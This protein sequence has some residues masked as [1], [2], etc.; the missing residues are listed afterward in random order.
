MAAA[1]NMSAGSAV[2]GVAQEIVVLINNAV[3]VVVDVVAGFDAGRAE[4]LRY[5]VGTMPVGAELSRSASMSA[6]TAVG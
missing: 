6:K 1:A 3:A 5:V 4:V 2:V